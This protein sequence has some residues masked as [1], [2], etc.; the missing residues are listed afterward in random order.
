MLEKLSL[1]FLFRCYEWE[2]RLVEAYINKYSKSVGYL[3]EQNKE[4]KV[5]I[6]DIWLSIQQLHFCKD[7]EENVDSALENTEFHQFT[8]NF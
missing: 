7:N 3:L 8:I 1:F 4:F 2:S 6:Q 5:S